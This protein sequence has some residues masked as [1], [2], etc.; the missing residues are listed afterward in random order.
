[1]AQVDAAFEQQILDVAEA[2]RKSD[3]H[4]DHQPD[5]LRRGVEITE[6]IV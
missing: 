3:V 5:H 2:Q 4:H 1:M 6:R